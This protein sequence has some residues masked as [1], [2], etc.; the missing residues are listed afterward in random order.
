MY[1][2]VISSREGCLTI[3]TYSLLE[4]ALNEASALSNVGYHVCVLQDGIMLAE[5]PPRIYR[6]N[7]TKETSAGEGY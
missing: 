1:T 4:D 3:D 5:Y 2:L 6:G 7:V